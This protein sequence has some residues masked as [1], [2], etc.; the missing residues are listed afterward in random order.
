M[1]KSLARRV[2]ERCPF[3]LGATRSEAIVLYA[4]VAQLVEHNLA[5]RALPRPGDH[6]RGP[7]PQ[8]ARGRAARRPRPLASLTTGRAMPPERP[9]GPRRTAMPFIAGGG[10]RV[11]VGPDRRSPSHARTGL[12]LRHTEAIGN[13]GRTPRPAVPGGLRRPIALPIGPTSI[14]KP[15]PEKR[16]ARRPETAR[17]P[18]PT[19]SVVHR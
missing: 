5:S 19:L 10:P 15:E 9:K 8:P 14:G 1:R 7:R 6:D 16:P 2:P 17:T 18:R 12:D 13:P 11:P 3:S 4:E